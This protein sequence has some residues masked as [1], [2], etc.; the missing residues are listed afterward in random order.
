MGWGGPNAARSM[1]GSV[2]ATASEDAI[3]GHRTVGACTGPG[4][5]FWGAEREARGAGLATA[6]AV[7]GSEVGQ[8]RAGADPWPEWPA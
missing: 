3:G 2:L 8:R 1:S 4:L 5:G 7:V 6:G